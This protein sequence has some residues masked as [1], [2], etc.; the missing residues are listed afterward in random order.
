RGT[1]AEAP[2]AA[3]ARSGAQGS[4]ATSGQDDKT[5]GPGGGGAT[6]RPDKAGATP[7][8][9]SKT[10]G[11]D[12]ETAG[13]DS[14]TAGPASQKPGQDG[15]KPQTDTGAAAG[16]HDGQSPTVLAP[17]PLPDFPRLR[18]TPTPPREKEASAE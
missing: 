14:E 2:P 8:Q 4:G 17:A 10:A 9:D 3:Q 18:S 7:G 12:S 13:P 5:G 11:P 1:A 6:P 15:K 16:D